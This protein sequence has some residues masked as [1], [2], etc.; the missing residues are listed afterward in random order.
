MHRNPIVLEPNFMAAGDR[1][2]ARD[3]IAA[4][5]SP[6]GAIIVRGR[7]RGGRDA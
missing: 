1:Q 4:G 5:Q 2:E 3:G 6:F 7:S